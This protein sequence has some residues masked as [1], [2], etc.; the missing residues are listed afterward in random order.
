MDNTHTLCQVITNATGKMKQGEG[1]KEKWEVG[2]VSSVGGGG[3][4]RVL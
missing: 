3:Q 2:A 1:V 4:E